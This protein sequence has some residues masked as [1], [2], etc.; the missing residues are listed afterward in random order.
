MPAGA[1]SS[2]CAWKE[3]RPET[4]TDHRMKQGIKR[5]R[6]RRQSLGGAVAM[7]YETDNEL[8]DSQQDSAR[9]AA[10]VVGGLPPGVAFTE[11]A[12]SILRAYLDGQ[13]LQSYQVFHCTYHDLHD[14]DNYLPALDDL[15]RW[16]PCAPLTEQGEPVTLLTY[17]RHSARLWPSVFLRLPKFQAVVARWY[18]LD[19]DGTARGIWMVAAPSAD[20]F[21][22]L[23]REVELR[24][25]D[26][27]A[28]VWQIVRGHPHCDG[29]RFP[30][31]AAD[32]LLLPPEIRRRI[33]TDVINFFSDEV[34]SLYR[35]LGVAHR[36][37]VL[38]HGPPGNGKT[39][40]I[41]FIGAALPKIP[42]M[43][44]RPAAGFDTDDLET[45]LNRWRKTA[46]AILVI[47]DLNW[48]LAAVNVSTFLN[49]LDGVDSNANAGQLLIAT[50]N[51]P[52][53][54]DPAI[55]NRPGRFDVVIEVPCPDHSLR[56]EFFRRK[57]S[58][59]G[60]E[61]IA[62]LAAATEGLSFSHLQEILRLSGLMVIGDGR[63]DRTEDDLLA[64]AKMV[65][66]GQEEAHGEFV[67]K[68][69]MPFGLAA[70]HRRS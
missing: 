68:P 11:R 66:R 58:E 25:H 51:H 20:H 2:H 41:R 62:R 9:P 8:R 30:R 63:T 61:F 34:V 50:T 4:R 48:L 52:D 44:L 55:N 16:E 12:A 70:W 64:A 3:I 6:K 39:S 38:L 23:H 22:R 46:P 33:E 57:V 59:G 18:W 45:V 56:L 24:R 19:S 10:P 28:V 65:S 29:E 32:E 47:E 37:G 49:L 27:G 7:L 36:R 40:T 21:F 54:L 31:E 35:K 13:E 15:A 69:V 1:I 67:S 26:A 60:Q 5:R 17:D 42:A 43:L 53:T 14:I